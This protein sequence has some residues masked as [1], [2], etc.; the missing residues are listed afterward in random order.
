MTNTALFRQVNLIL[1]SCVLG[2]ASLRAAAGDA[3][4]VTFAYTFGTPHRLTVALPDSSGK[5]LLD[6]YQGRLEML[7]T[8][9]DL[10]YYSFKSYSHPVADWKVVLTP[11]VDGQPFA[12]STWERVD[13]FLPVLKNRYQSEGAE[14]VLE[15]AGASTAAIAKITLAN[16]GTQARTVTLNCEVPGKWTGYNPAWVDHEVAADHLLAGWKA[17]ADQV[18]MLGIGADEYPLVGSNTV[19]MRWNLKPGERK[20][21]WLI[22]PYKNEEAE[23]AGLR[24]ENWTTPFL[25]A[26]QQWTDLLHQASRLTIPDVGVQ[27][28]FYACL[29]DLFIMRE[30]MAKGYIATVPGTDL[31]RAAPNSFESAIV[32]VALDQLGLHSLAELGYRVNLD[33]QSPDG[34]WSESKGWGHLMWGASGFKSWAIVEHY[35]LS[36]DRA[37]LERRFP[38]MLACSRWQEKQRARTRITD[39]GGQRRLTY[40]L[41]PRGMGDAGLMAMICMAFSMRG[42]SGPY[43]RMVLRQKPRRSWG[44]HRKRRN[45]MGS[46]SEAARIYCSHYSGER[47]RRQM[48]RV[49]SQPCQARPR[50]A[51]MEC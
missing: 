13:G 14:L 36:G 4:S 8:Y 1:F 33:L 34:D 40:G 18:V 12:R 29:A 35:L 39:S 28:A 32:T 46:I 19:L 21:A 6:A 3:P 37:F 2:T 30:P 27:N 5:T 31:Y 17:P 45:S 23:V 51:A 42:I 49:G 41:M 7:W 24:R 10:I 25:T 11:T 44:V 9:E 47:S 48:E 20:E 50:G 43:M 22:R 16:S 15:I 38:Q 26:H